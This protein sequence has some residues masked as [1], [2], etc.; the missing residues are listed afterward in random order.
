MDYRLEASYWERQS[1]VYRKNALYY[2]GTPEVYSLNLGRY[3]AFCIVA[4]HYRQ[5]AKET[6]Q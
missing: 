1:E 5:L 6:N 4:N 3:D 2:V